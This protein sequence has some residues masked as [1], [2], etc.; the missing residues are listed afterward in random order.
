MPRPG[1][2]ANSLPPSVPTS[3]LAVRDVTSLIG[4]FLD[5]GNRR[6]GQRIPLPFLLELEPCETSLL[7]PSE[8][9]VV[10]GK[11]L[12]ESGIGFFH[13]NRIPCQRVRL[14]L[15]LAGIGPLEL[16]CEMLWCHFTRHGWYESGARIVAIEAARLAVARAG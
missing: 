8:G 9:T 11:D 4:S 16:I 10:V 15:E 5:D 14:R 1:L 6:H 12:S 7:A 3:P 13:Q 2:C